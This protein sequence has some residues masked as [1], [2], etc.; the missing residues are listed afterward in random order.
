MDVVIVGSGTYGASLAWWLARAG[1]SVTIVDQFEPGDGRASSG[2]ETR[3][4]RCAHGHD[5]EYTAMA[6]RARTLWRELEEESGEELLVEC[7]MAWF[8]HR[9]DGWESEAERALAEQG[10][11]VERLDVA[12]AARLYPSFRGDDLAFVLLEPE[13]GVLRAERSVRALAKQAVAHGAR[14]VRARARPDGAAVVLDDGTRLTGDIVVWACGPWLAHLFDDLIS[15]TVTQQELLF[16]DGGPAWRA[17]GLPGWCDYERARYGTGDIDA[18]G[19][20]AAIDDLG[21]PLDADAELPS[22]TNTEPEVR[23]YMRERFPALEDAPLVGARSCRYDLT[24]DTRF[25][26]APHPANPN[27]WLVGGGSG[28]GFKHGPPMAERL[29]AAF[30]TGT[31]LPA[32]FGLAERSRSRSLRTASSGI[33]T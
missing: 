16:L 11:P 26:A 18:L 25:I 33:A 21:P 28:H 15:L 2:G 7:G 9:E 10:I 19:I 3:L 27:V 17:P 14:I 24:P 20:K 1:E 5:T 12:S 23:A 6:R 8:A 29:A 32:D 13:G 4:Y 30:S 22:T 31:T